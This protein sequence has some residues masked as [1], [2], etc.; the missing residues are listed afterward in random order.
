MTSSEPHR[1]VTKENVTLWLPH[2]RP[3][4]CPTALRSSCWKGP[5]FHH[6]LPQ[7][8][9][10]WEPDSWESPRPPNTLVMKASPLV[11]AADIF[12]VSTNEGRDCLTH[13]VLS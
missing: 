7:A 8:A 2:E 13:S 10:H 12:L 5:D 9:G 4:P 3:V 6:R 11:C 1:V